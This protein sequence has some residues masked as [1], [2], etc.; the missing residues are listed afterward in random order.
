[1]TLEKG[2]LYRFKKLVFVYDIND[3]QYSF[4]ENTTFLVLNTEDVINYEKIQFLIG[5]KDYYHYI[6]KDLINSIYEL[7]S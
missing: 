2:K 4:E 5:D 7:I 3:K 6:K 1:M